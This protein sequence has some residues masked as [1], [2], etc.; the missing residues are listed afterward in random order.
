MPEHDLTDFDADVA[1]V[2]RRDLGSVTPTVDP[3]ATARRAMAATGDRVGWLRI[4]GAAAAAVAVMV[5]VGLVVS[6]RPAGEAPPIVGSGT[7]PTPPPP[8][9]PSASPSESE[10]AGIGRA[11]WALP[12]DEEI[13]RGTVQFTAL[14]RERACASGRS[15]EGRIIGPDITYTDEAVIVTFQVQGL[16]GAQDCQGNPSTATQ[17]TLE[18][19][20]G[21]RRLLDGDSDPPREPPRCEPGGYCD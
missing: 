9:S 2:L 3:E 11:S 7:T 10:P 5:V 4:F 19:A 6:P 15:S 1:R 8:P 18:E 21:D 20:L 16:S 17:V 14:V 13:G 12:T